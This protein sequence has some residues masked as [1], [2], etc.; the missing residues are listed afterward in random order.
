MT[1]L[2]VIERFHSYSNWVTQFQQLVTITPADCYES[3]DYSVIHPFPS[4]VMFLFMSVL[5]WCNLYN[6]INYDEIIDKLNIV[7]AAYVCV[8]LIYTRMT[9]ISFLEQVARS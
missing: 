3:Y 1:N 8:R 9:V 6:T 5:C 4:N 2:S 7:F